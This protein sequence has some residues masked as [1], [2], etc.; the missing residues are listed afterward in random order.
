MCAF[1]KLEG[2]RESLSPQSQSEAPP[3]DQSVRA[4]G[5]TKRATDG[6][7]NRESKSDVMMKRANASRVRHRPRQG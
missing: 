2:Q 1:V 3:P 5:I 6:P 7:T 4:V